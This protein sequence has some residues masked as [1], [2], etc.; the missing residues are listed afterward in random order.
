MIQ[1]LKM[2]VA[3]FVIISFLAYFLL[4]KSWLMSSPS[5]S[6]LCV[7]PY[8]LLNQLVDIYEIQ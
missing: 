2:V 3:V 6:V 4:K 7:P 5:L 8:Q 1:L